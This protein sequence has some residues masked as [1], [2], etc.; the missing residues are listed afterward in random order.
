MS[1]LKYI[2]RSITYYY[3]QH[4]ALFF[5][6]VISAT[7]LAGALIIGDSIDYSLNKLIDIRLGKTDY[8]VMSGSRF[9][10]AELA[11]KIAKETELEVTPLLLLKSIAINST[12]GQRVNNTNI[13]GIDSSFNIITLKPIPIP[14]NNEAIIGNTLAKRLQLKV[15]DFLL[16]RIENGNLVPVNAPFSR[17]PEPTVALRVKVLAIADDD[18]LARLN[19][20]NEQNIPYNV[21]VS[22]KMLGEKLELT[23]LSNVLLIDVGNNDISASNIKNSIQPQWSLKDLGLKIENRNEQTFD[24]T[25]N[26]VFI[27]SVIVSAV[28]KTTYNSQN[29]LTYL[30]NDIEANGKHTPYSFAS[31][32]EESISGIALKNDEILINQWTADDLKAKPGDS[33]LITYFVI[34]QLRDLK[35]VSRRFVIKQIIENEA[36]GIDRNLMPDF[37]GF[38]EAGSCS[39]WDAGV[40]ID[41]KRIRD[42]DEAY[43]DNYRGTPKVILP[44]ETGLQMWQ[45]QFGV[46]TSLRFNAREVSEKEIS[47]AI[48]KNVH[49]TDL[50]IDVISVREEGGTAAKNAV[51]FTELFLSMSFF[52]ILAGILLTLLIYTLH[53]Q[54]RNNE[55]ALLSGL[56]FGQNRI[57]K[58][59]I[60]ETLLIVFLGSIF[61]TFIGI[62]YNKGLIAG[63]NTLWYDIVRTDVLIVHIK[64]NTLIMSA[65]ISGLIALIPL[66]YVTKKQLKKAIAG[67]ISSNALS[68]TQSTRKRKRLFVIA[69]V[70]L[71]FAFATVGYSLATA[72]VN[73]AGLY[74]GASSLVLL[75]GIILFYAYLKKPYLDQAH[76]IPSAKKIAF[77]NLQRNAGRTIS[78]II[79]L[80]IGTFT[81]VITGANRK[82]FYGAEQNRTSGTG[83]YALWAETTSPV[84]FDLNS[85]EGQERLLYDSLAQLENV[86]FLQFSRLDGDEA[87]CHNLNQVQRPRLLAINPQ[88]FNDVGAFTFVD[89]LSFVSKESPWLSL[90]TA[91]NE[92]TYAAYVDQ[93]VLTYSLQKKLGDTLH[94]TNEFGEPFNLVLAGAINNTIFQGNILVSQQILREQ[95]PS[96][97]GSKTIL[98][99][100]PLNKQEAVSK[101]LLESLV[102]YGIEVTPTSQRLANFYSVTNTYLTIF[103]ALSGLGF[104]IGTIGLGIILLRNMQERRKELALLLA[105]GY[106]KKLI[107]KIVFIENLYLLI[108]GLAI[109]IIA[110]FIGILP[111]L[112]SPAFNLEGMFLVILIGGIFLSGLAWIYFPLRSALGKPLIPSLRNE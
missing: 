100:A 30:V 45:N 15:D 74:M 8:A 77:K 68:E 38:S 81:V 58:L 106:S 89:Q 20:K 43:W 19:L 21:F 23:G 51:N 48:L 92:T 29:I 41:L 84:I 85:T 79:L 97:G 88:K 72:A 78:V 80:A 110:A 33:A 10:D 18:Q 83:G 1:T 70:F 47:S 40:P 7:V 59:R 2:I 63:L 5:G 14:Q 26:R 49:P 9:M 109:G 6:V 34:G 101:I 55:T 64:T 107:F 108:S 46:L 44:F 60:A 4:L 28:K 35:E 75:G 42:K 65:F 3:K 69:G 22:S 54:K 13:A 103:M 99:D 91:L 56:G 104:I 112:L 93:T 50:G 53:F 67:Q 95:F 76:P 36:P 24:I 86:D 11:K 27:D 37:Q 25:S 31:A 57:I 87:S 52:I 32:L 111:S 62:L 73:N 90:N 82:T 71:I 96:L 102:D 61:G 66:Y 98:I 94:Y 17:E 16:L 12:T 39:E 105:T